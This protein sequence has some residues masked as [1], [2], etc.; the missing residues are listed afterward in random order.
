[1]I[2]IIIIINNEDRL[3]TNKFILNYKYKIAKTNPHEVL[4]S[5]NKQS[6]FGNKET[7]FRW[8]KIAN[9]AE[10]IELDGRNGKRNYAVLQ[11]HCQ[12]EG[13]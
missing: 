13:Y 11:I 10:Y 2:E 8:Q 4:K 12:A 1:M 7:R 3:D 5:D 6:N 9:L